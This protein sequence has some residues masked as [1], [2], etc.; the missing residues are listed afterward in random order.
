M[1]EALPVNSI[2]AA[3]RLIELL[4]N[5]DTN[6]ILSPNARADWRVKAIVWFLMQQLTGVQ[7]GN[8]DMSNLYD[9]I[10]TLRKGALVQ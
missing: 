3:N 1:S 7:I 4:R 8:V 9:T 5:A 10:E 2:A 6:S